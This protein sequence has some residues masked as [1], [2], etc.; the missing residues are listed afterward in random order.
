MFST[1]GQSELKASLYKW[2]ANLLRCPLSAFLK[3]RILQLLQ[4]DIFCKMKV[5]NPRD[6]LIMHCL[7]RNCPLDLMR[8]RI[9]GI[10]LLDEREAEL[11]VR[12]GGEDGG[13]YGVHL[14]S[15]FDSSTDLT[16]WATNIVTVFDMRA[17]YE[18]GNIN[19]AVVYRRI[20]H[21]FHA[22]G[23][24][25]V[26]IRG[27]LTINDTLLKWCGEY[28]KSSPWCYIL[29]ED[30]NLTWNWPENCDRVSVRS[31]EGALG[32]REHRN[33]KFY[34]VSYQQQEAEHPIYAN[35]NQCISYPSFLPS[36]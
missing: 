1:A 35:V 4:Y 14:V 25:F 18:A 11:L 8:A 33:L 28:T 36:F 29:L 34:R 32:A 6:R 3:E 21:A 9:D 20:L 12:L 27:L 17:Q 2:I 22:N 7:S 31:T 19:D 5:E 24:C 10:V 30:T 23:A 13:M 15:S 16:T 26:Y